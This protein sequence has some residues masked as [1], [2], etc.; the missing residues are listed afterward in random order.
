[1][2]L[3][4][5]FLLLLSP[6]TVTHTLKDPDPAVPRTHSHLF[7]DLCAGALEI[8]RKTMRILL[9]AAPRPGLE[10]SDLPEA[11]IVSE[12]KAERHRAVIPL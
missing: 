8:H 6:A 3:E 4:R 7:L 10:T 9:C 1:M 11:S 2:G 5:S 12:F